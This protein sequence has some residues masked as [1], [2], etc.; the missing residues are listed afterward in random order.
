MV[1]FH[2]T[3]TENIL[4]LQHNLLYNLNKAAFLSLWRCGDHG[5]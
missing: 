3:R 1:F 5:E 4:A 2:S